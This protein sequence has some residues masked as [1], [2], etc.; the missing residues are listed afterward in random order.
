MNQENL[1][2]LLYF[3]STIPQVI[4]AMLA[5]IGVFVVLRLEAIR[6]EILG[7]SKGIIDMKPQFEINPIAEQE[8]I[9]LIKEIECLIDNIKRDNNSN[10]IVGLY[11][12]SKDLN[13]ILKSDRLAQSKTGIPKDLNLHCKGILDV[14]KKYNIFRKVTKQVFLVNGAIIL[15]FLF[16][17]L[18]VNRVICHNNLFYYIL[19]SGLLFT[20]VSLASMINFMLHSVSNRIQKHIFDFRWNDF[21]I[22]NRDMK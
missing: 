8:S 11:H 3:L 22:N 6:K 1:T 19:V 9:K 4:G 10:N 16:T 18:F 21:R 12:E 2:I 5:L 15:S 20:T 14:S 7:V 17:F 13:T